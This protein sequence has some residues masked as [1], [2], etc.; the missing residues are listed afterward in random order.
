MTARTI[1]L[2]LYSGGSLLFLAGSIVSLVWV[3]S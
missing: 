2:L 3:K 1:A